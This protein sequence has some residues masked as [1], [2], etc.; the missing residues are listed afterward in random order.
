V[1][2][3][4]TLDAQHPDPSGIARAAALLRDGR[5]V[6]FPTE[7]V[8][9]L[10]AHALDVQ[11]VRRIFAAKGR[12]AHDPLIVHVHDLSD[13]ARLTTGIPP[14]AYAL[15]ARFWPGPLTMVLRR[16]DIV[17]PE[18]TANLDTVAIRVPAHPVAR[19][20]IAAAALPIAAPSANLFSRPSPTRAAHVLQDL[21]GRRADRGGCREHGRRSDGSGADD[22]AARRRHA[23][24]APLGGSR[25]H[26]AARG[27]G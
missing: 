22:P 13:V 19:A 15:A 21:D 16:S 17:P 4:L 6:A 26:Y 20:L 18:V 12:P 25:G 8:Y 5:L 24:D 14:A 3:V 10:G 9:G 27:I 2:D 1:T 11:A 7:T 23:R